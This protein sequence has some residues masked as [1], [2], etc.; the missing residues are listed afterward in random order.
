MLTFAFVS[1]IPRCLVNPPCCVPLAFYGNCS[2]VWSE[3]TVIVVIDP[4]LVIIARVPVCSVILCDGTWIFMHT[5]PFW[6]RVSWE[7]VHYIVPLRYLRSS[8]TCDAASIGCAIYPIVAHASPRSSGWPRTTGILHALG[9]G[10]EASV[11][12]GVFG[13]ACHSDAI[14]SFVA[15]K[16]VRQRVTVI[17]SRRSYAMKKNLA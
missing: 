1:C 3:A 14:L 9:S 8:S 4:K 15:S 5:F 16:P 6:L 13:E 17:D 11:V 2:R 12:P 7:R 10:V